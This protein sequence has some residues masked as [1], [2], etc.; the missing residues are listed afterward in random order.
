MLSLNQK[1]EKLEQIIFYS[2]DKAIR[3]YRQF[4]QQQLKQAGFSMTVDQWLVIKCILQNPDI[5]QQE[6]AERVFKDNASVTRIISLLVREK[7]LSRKIMKSNRRRTVLQVTDLG[8]KTI[9]SIDK[10][11]LSNRKTALSGISTEEIEISKKVMDQIA[12]NCK[13]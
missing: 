9:A 7:Y 11:V 6:I 13:K 4:A 5:S 8:K 10:I 3:T 1:V 2:I 12:E